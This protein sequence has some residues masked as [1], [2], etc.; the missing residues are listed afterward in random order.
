MSTGQQQPSE[1]RPLSERIVELLKR[2]PSQKAVELARTLGVERSDVN[3]CLSHTLAGKVQQ[4]NAYRWRLRDAG[5]TAS[6]GGTPGTQAPVTELERLCRYYLECIGQDSD[7]GVSVF[8]ANK[9][10]EPDYAELSAVPLPGADWDWWNAPGAG[11]VLGRVRAERGKLIAYIGYPVRLRRHRTARWEGFFVEPVML[12]PI[13]LP[14]NPGDPYALQDDLPSPNFAFLKSLAVGDPSQIMQE[15]AAL[16][17]DLGLNNPLED[18][19]EA[20]ELLLRL[21]SVRPDWDWKE[22]LDFEHC[23]QQPPL[24]QINEVGIYNRAVILAG[25][26]SPYTQGL[27]SELKALSEKA[28]A[29]VF[30]TA[31]GS[32]LSGKFPPEAQADGEPLI[33]VLPMNSEQ[34]DAVRSALTAPLTVVTG[35]PGTG[36]SQVVTNLLVNAAWRGMKVLFAS[37][38][39]KAVDVVEARVNGLGNRPVL[40]R[41]GSREYQAKLGEYMAAMLSGAVSKDDEQ[42]YQEGLER[43]RHLA[44]RVKQL[45]EAQEKTLNAR[46]LVDQ[47]DAR[48]EDYRV[49]FGAERFNHLDEDLVERAN[50]SLGFYLKAI[51][52]ADA[53]KQH[54]LVRLFYFLLRGRRNAALLKATEQVGLLAS[55]L[56]VTLPRQTASV[57]IDRHHKAAAELKQRVA[58]AEQVL[59]YQ[60]AL[61]VLRNNPAFEDIA[62]QRQEL[63]EQVARNSAGLWR[64]FVQLT[65]SRL[66]GEQR[67]AVSDYAALLQ[68]MNGP[69]AQNLTPAVRN[70]ARELQSR[71]T[72]IFS[73]WAVTSLSARGK[74][75]FEPGYFDLVVIDEASQCDIASALPLLYRAKRAVIIGDPMQLSHISSMTKQKE[76]ELQQK[77]GLIETRAS[78]MYSVNSLY[79]LAAGLSGAGSIINLRDHHRSHADIIEFSNKAF[80]GGKLRVA[81]R[82]DN[83][84]RPR[85]TEP[86]V[87]WQDA[88]GRTVRP[89]SGGAEN[90]QEA[91]ALVAALRDLLIV[92]GYEGSVGVVTPFRAQAQ[93]L[94]KTIH[95]DAELDAIAQRRDLLVD[96]VHKF[97]GDERDV[98]FFS[99]VISADA[100]QG[101][102]SFLRSNGNLFNVAITRAR[103]LLHVVGDR[104][105]AAGCGVDYLADFARYAADLAAV[106]E[107]TKP[108]DVSHLGSDYPVVSNP[109]RVSD[110][111]RLFYRELYRAGLRPIPQFSVE[112]YDLDFALFVGDRQ[113]NLEVDGERYHRSWTGELCL[114]DQLR[115]QRLI[116]LGWEVKRFWVYEIRDR[117]DECVAWVQDWAAK[118]TETGDVTFKSK[119]RVH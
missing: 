5:G 115:N 34:R 48:A 65:P 96:T 36:K 54:G 47:L 80:Y 49:L 108:L 42:S 56:G 52:G 93:R 13:A 57:D 60:Q 98:M 41:L 30:G 43:H 110:W 85:K 21:H 91:T 38:N 4:D 69:D 100:P 107:Q 35:P 11:R 22:K 18:Q 102:L 71:V 82:Y 50:G 92:R 104:S 1:N 87:I 31:L 66:T 16:A 64:D 14:E 94:Q 90:P 29:N 28:E 70:R 44:E 76:S 81:T 113:L 40:L 8:A 95:A 84:K 72:A 10:G 118:A 20:D 9:Y 68:L 75:P 7:Q 117:M 89:S 55:H 6:Q 67:K 53:R 103:G 111:E 99:P 12:W 73:C 62:R 58:A 24:A 45:D 51:D 79:A 33:E 109:E 3:R 77:Y 32:W 116:E 112:Q 97:Q 78:W 83:L 88:R 59:A 23:S 25:E 37:K 86:G 106:R 2:K 15:A 26:R 46:N 119:R 19:P 17:S 39:N 101:A 63:S 105:A 61:G 27:E 114:R 74:I